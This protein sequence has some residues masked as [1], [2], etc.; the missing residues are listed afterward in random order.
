MIIQN[1]LCDCVFN[2]PRK[3]LHFTDL[4]SPETQLFFWPFCT[5]VQKKYGETHLLDPNNQKKMGQHEQFAAAKNSPNISSNRSL[6]T[7]VYASSQVKTTSSK[8]SPYVLEIKRTL[9]FQRSKDGLKTTVQLPHLK[10]IQRTHNKFCYKGIYT[11][12]TYHNF[13]PCNSRSSA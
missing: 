13:F 6:Q 7:T 11:Y 12:K 10:K 8:L 5:T 3:C 4:Q 1:L 2:F 9:L